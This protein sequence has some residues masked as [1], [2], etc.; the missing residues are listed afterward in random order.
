MLDSDCR[1]GTYIFSILYFVLKD[2]KQF[3]NPWNQ[4]LQKYKLL[5]CTF[6]SVRHWFLEM[7][8]SWN[9][10]ENFW[11]KIIKKIRKIVIK[12]IKIRVKIVRSFSFSFW[13]LIF[14]VSFLRIL[15]ENGN[16]PNRHEGSC[17]E[18]NQN[19]NGSPGGVYQASLQ[20]SPSCHRRGGYSVWPSS[21]TLH[22][23][24]QSA[25]QVLQTYYQNI[26]LRTWLDLY[27]GC[28]VC[29]IYPSCKGWGR[30]LAENRTNS[31]QG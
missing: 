14:Q 28:C 10:T 6:F 8:P 4:C 13:P 24:G 30:T 9:R 3:F 18:E 7:T 29:Q 5:L 11:I 26:S 17:R 1:I 2:L 19:S 20:P 15:P 23:H 12:I 27:T 22:Y 31:L 16:Q 25:S 21:S